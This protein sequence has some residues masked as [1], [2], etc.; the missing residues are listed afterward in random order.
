MQTEAILLQ[1][2]LLL[3]MQGLSNRLNQIQAHLSHLPPVYLIYHAEL[4]KNE[5]RLR[6]LKWRHFMTMME[7][8]PPLLRLSLPLSF[9]RRGASYGPLWDCKHASFR[10][11]NQR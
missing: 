5:M 4:S 7:Q 3:Y 11:G 6:A 1:Q 9:D 2:C 8:K 10:H